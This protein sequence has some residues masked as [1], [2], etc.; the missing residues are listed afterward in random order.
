MEGSWEAEG[1]NHVA[2]GWELRQGPWVRPQ[3]IRMVGESQEAV[4][5]GGGS[6]PSSNKMP[7]LEEYGTNLTTQATEVGRSQACVQGPECSTSLITCALV[8]QRPARCLLVRGVVSGAAC[9]AV[10]HNLCMGGMKAL[11][12]YLIAQRLRFRGQLTR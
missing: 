7:T 9:A 2:R 8:V 12:A 4:G 1:S 3:V 11:A 5:V 10:S 6:G